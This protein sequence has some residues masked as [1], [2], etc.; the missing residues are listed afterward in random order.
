MNSIDIW[1]TPSLHA[2][3]G[4]LC[5]ALLFYR[6]IHSGEKPHACTLCGKRFTASSNLYYHKMTH[7]KVKLNSV[8]SI[9]IK[10]FQNYL[11]IS[12]FRTNCKNVQTAK[13]FLELKMSWKIINLYVLWIIHFWNVIFVSKHFQKKW[14]SKTIYWNICLQI[15]Q[16]QRVRK[17]P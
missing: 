17:F 5:M 11:K 1:Q 10:L 2:C 13:K 6:R 7:K 12:I 4:S 9:V 14:N 3:L 15:H 8:T 16:W